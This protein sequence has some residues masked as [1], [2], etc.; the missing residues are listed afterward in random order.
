MET[1]WKGGS[2][3]VKTFA[4]FWIFS[5]L[6]RE[7]LGQILL[8]LLV[9]WY[10]DNRYVG[11]LAALWAPVAR[12]QRIAGLRGAVRENPSDIRSMVELGDHYLHGGNHQAAAEY[13]EKAFDRGEDSPR[14]L[15]L[16][17]AAW[18]KLG[19]HAEGRAK[20]EE[21]VAK[22]PSTAYGEPYIY[23]LEEALATSS[24]DNPRI[25][26]L[27]GELKQFDSV[28]ILTRAGRL[29]LAAG[30]K[31]LAKRLFDEAIHNYG[32]IPKK[33]RRRERRWLVRAR[34]GQIQA[35]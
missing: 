24:A 17:G 1:V 13:L 7:P 4:L 12:Y 2:W 33:M 19:R 3:L 35:K 31:D 27:V 23:L 22:Q 10:L 29:C 8:A 21:A 32:F 20:L 28:E 5:W 26:D 11:L 15:Y 30:R 25:D 14:A 9:F 6:I 16:L 34:L 18:V